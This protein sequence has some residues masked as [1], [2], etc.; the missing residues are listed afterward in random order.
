MRSTS[1]EAYWSLEHLTEKQQKVFDAIR[2]L[3]I[4][5]GPPTDVNIGNFLRWPI[6]RITP[7]RG[8][9]EIKGWIVEHGKVIN[10]NG[11]TACTWVSLERHEELK[12]LRKNQM[13]LF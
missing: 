4:P 10:E 7:R 5:H 3:E 12:E 11:R 2:V 13:Q 6:N 8:E 1:L 9:L